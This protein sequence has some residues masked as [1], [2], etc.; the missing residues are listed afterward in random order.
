MNKD[1]NV[2]TQAFLMISEHHIGVTDNL[3]DVIAYSN[4]HL[5]PGETLILKKGYSEEL[6]IEEQ[7]ILTLDN[8]RNSNGN[9]LII[10]HKQ[11]DFNLIERNSSVKPVLT[12]VDILNNE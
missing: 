12:V 7:K 4:D 2:S 5:Q 8:L 1:D 11:T 10:P 3:A 6:F 9:T